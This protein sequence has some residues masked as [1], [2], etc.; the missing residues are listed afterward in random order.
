M[1]FHIRN[2]NTEKLVR[3]LAR[4][5]KLGLTEAVHVA[6]ENELGRRRQAIPLWERIAPLRRRV[7]ARVKDNRP[8]DKAFRD[9]LYEARDDRVR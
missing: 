5:A 2:R 1:A 8:T 3:E 6:V 7:S 9:D 4:T